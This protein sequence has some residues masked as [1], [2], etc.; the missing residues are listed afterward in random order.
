LV[1][2]LGKQ[3]IILGYPWFKQANPDINWKKR[4]LVWR[5]GQDKKAQESKV[6]IEEEIDPED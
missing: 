4:T 2:G 6:I 3:K 1:T 5:N